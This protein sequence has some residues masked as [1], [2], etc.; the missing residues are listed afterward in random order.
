LDEW[1]IVC[2]DSNPQLIKPTSPQQDPTYFRVDHQDSDRWAIEGL[3]ETWKAQGYST[4]SILHLTVWPQPRTD[5]C[6]F[7]LIINGQHGMTAIDISRTV[8]NLINLP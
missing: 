3:D 5:H 8:R 1:A 7:K 4:Y 2:S 6:L